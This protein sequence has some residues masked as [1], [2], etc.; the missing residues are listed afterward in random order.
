MFPASL[1]H[2]PAVFGAYLVRICIGSI[3]FQD[4]EYTHRELFNGAH[5]IQSG[6]PAVENFIFLC[7]GVFWD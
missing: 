2:V 3:T 1:P 7:L 5:I 4:P 6:P